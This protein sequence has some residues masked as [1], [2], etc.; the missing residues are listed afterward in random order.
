MRGGRMARRGK[1]DKGSETGDERWEARDICPRWVLC[2][3][4]K[5]RFERHLRTV[6]QCCGSGSGQ[7]RHFLPDPDPYKFF[8]ILIRTDTDPK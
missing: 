6:T 7:I 5:C 4:R 3:D 8:R 1:R 2:Y